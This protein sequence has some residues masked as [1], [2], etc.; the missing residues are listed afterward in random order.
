[1]LKGTAL[2][3][4]LLVAAGCG[5]VEKAGKAEAVEFHLVYEKVIGEKG[6]W[7]ADVD[8]SH[9]RLLVPRGHLPAISP[10]GKWVTYSGECAE[11]DTSSCDTLYIVSTTHADKPRRLS[12]VV[13]GTIVWSPDSK[14]VVGESIG[15]LLSIEVASGK[16]VEVADG[17][18]WGWSISPDG[19][20]IV[21]ARL[22]DPDAELVLGT[23]VNLFVAGQDGGTAKR[24]TDTGYA[25]EP[26]WGPKSITFAKL[27]SCLPPAPQDALDQCKNNTW[28]RHEIWQIEPDGSGRKTITGPLPDRLQAQGFTGLTPTTVPTTVVLCSAVGPTSGGVCRWPST[29]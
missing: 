1:V 4:V 20:Q 23:E 8:G 13:S 27:I 24:I 15:K 7:I 6:I 3:A 22:E 29:R 16:A 19:E 17:T 21:F 14:R 9:A 5:S 26:V 2:L 12:T 18:F 25:S 10:D 11:S 28:G